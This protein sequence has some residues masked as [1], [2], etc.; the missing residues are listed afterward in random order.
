RRE[1]VDHE[2]DPPVR[3]DIA[4]LPA[5]GHVA[6][7]DIDRVQRRVVE[8]PDRTV[9]QRAV[10][11]GGR[12]PPQPLRGQV[13]DFAVSKDHG[14]NTTFPRTCR[15]SMSWCAHTASA[16]GY[17]AW[18]FTVSRPSAIIEASSASCAWDRWVL[19]RR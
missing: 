17:R 6:A 4:V 2:R 1:V 11:L 5:G 15:V 12:E 16:S 7:A 10:G 14:S 8:E 19:R 9:L 3:R 18:I 13:L